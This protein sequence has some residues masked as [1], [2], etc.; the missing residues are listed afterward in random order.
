MLLK[1][2]KII[3]PDKLAEVIL[4]GQDGLVNTFGVILG[5]AAAS[6]DIKIVIAGGLAATIAESISMGAV[7]YTSQRADRDHYLSE[8]KIQN[9]LIDEDPVNQ[10]E[11]VKKIYS[12]KGF[13]GERL[14]D[15]TNLI[16]SN[17][18]T[19]LAIIM[20]DKIKLSSIEIRDVIINSLIVLISALIGAL[21]PLAPFFFLPL[22]QSIIASFV[23]S[24]AALFLFGYYKG[25]ITL[26]HALYSGVELL[27]I[28]MS[29]ALLGYAIGFVFK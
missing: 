28:G 8:L 18:K 29:A 7:A 12:Q 14:N 6:G 13:E 24:S 5:V 15:I 3:P 21:I 17:K 10:K 9:R 2:K 27:L 22:Y 25:K 19:W 4:G 16:V 23:F 20:S 11:I 1:F 26:G